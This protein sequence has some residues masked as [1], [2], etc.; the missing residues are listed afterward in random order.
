VA[1]WRNGW[2]HTGDLLRRD[3]CGN[4][5]FV[6]RASDSLRRRGE[7][8]S[9]FEVERAV[10]HHPDVAE[11]GC[12][13]VSDQRNDQ[14]VMIYVVPV[15]G[16]EIKPASLVHFLVPRLP[17]FALPRYIEVVDELPKTPTARV[18][19]FML[20]ERGVTERTWDREA[21]GIVFKRD[22]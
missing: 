15:A 4:Y 14:D 17:Y 19:K 2:F 3:R 1:A 8:I 5:Y 6:D 16:R 18:R 13:G 9:S 21:A 20:R 7:N 22:Y 10:M 12:I 11:V